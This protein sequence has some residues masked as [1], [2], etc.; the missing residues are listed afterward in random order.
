[1]ISNRAA[2][3]MGPLAGSMGSVKFTADHERGDLPCP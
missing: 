3:D 2:C 1:M